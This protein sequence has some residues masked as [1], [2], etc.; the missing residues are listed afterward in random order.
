MLQH[1]A[2]SKER[3]ESRERI[4]KVHLISLL[5]VGL[6]LAT[7]QVSIAASV[8]NKAAKTQKYQWT[9]ELCENEGY[10][11]SSKVSKKNI[12][13]GFKIFERLTRVNLSD[14]APNT[15]KELRT[16]NNQSIDKLEKEYRQLNNQVEGLSTIP[17]QPTLDMA[18]FKGKLQQDITNEYQLQRLEL[19][20]YL[21]I[22]KALKAAPKVC[23][24]Y[25][26]PLS[27]GSEKLQAAWK[28]QTLESIQKQEKLANTGY[29]K[30]AMD[31]YRS[32]QAKDADSYAK[33][34]LVG[35]AWHNCLNN[36]HSEQELTPEQVN[37]GQQAFEK[38]VFKNTKKSEC[39]EP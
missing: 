15:P 1:V 30:L 11:D 28:A 22:E 23:Q 18:F 6:S 34:N 29:R 17:K 38:F 8:T 16:L 36:H 24:G 20:A 19:M 12:D 2:D 9:D 3:A 4:M 13:D 32:E 5:A 33:L 35:Y 10:Y 7:T 37:K 26:L 21:D 27:Q 39:E 31:R 14:Y 25:L